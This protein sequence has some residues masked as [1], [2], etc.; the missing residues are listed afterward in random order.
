M[1]ARLFFLLILTFFAELSLLLW[2]ADRFGW[3]MA[4]AEVLASAILGVLVVR[5][6]NVKIL[7]RVRS[8]LAAGETPTATVLHGV[9][10]LFAGLLLVM[11][12]ILTDI[13][14][15]LLLIP[16]FRKLLGLSAALW[17]HRRFRT[18]SFGSNLTG[19]MHA[20]PGTEQPDTGRPLPR[21]IDVQVIDRPAD[22]TRPAE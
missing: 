15:L 11:P 1:L 14:G 5:W 4:L 2:F 22:S 7:Q 12:G 13:L 19:T 20:Q 10:I 17:I 6:Q 8:Q 21:I 18:A 9:L 16:P 3:R